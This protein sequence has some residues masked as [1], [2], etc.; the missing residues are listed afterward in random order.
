[1]CQ[2]FLPC[3]KTLDAR[4][5]ELILQFQSFC[6]LLTEADLSTAAL[7]HGDKFCDFFLHRPIII[8]HVRPMKV[9]N[10]KYITV[11][12]SEATL[13]LT[14]VKIRIFGPF[15]EKRRISRGKFMF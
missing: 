3:I 4:A 7:G 6:S 15:S 10:P 11:K 2:I 14:F 9:I 5:E 13:L 12:G 1:M 8:S